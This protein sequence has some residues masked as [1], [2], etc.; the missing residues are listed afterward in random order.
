M[1]TLS[2]DGDPPQ[3]RS[4]ISPSL[5]LPLPLCGDEKSCSPC[6]NESQ[7]FSLSSVYSRVDV[8]FPVCPSVDTGFTG[9]RWDGTKKDGKT[10]ISIKGTILQINGMTSPPPPSGPNHQFL[11]NMQQPTERKTHSPRKSE[12]CTDGGR[13]LV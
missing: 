10:F 6:V 9:V 4:S 1:D 3:S 13:R 8:R 11:C 5:R 7:L 2:R 12:C